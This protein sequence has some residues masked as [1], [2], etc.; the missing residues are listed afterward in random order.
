MKTFNLLH[1]LAAFG[2]LG[3]TTAA[4]AQVDTSG[5][6]C[7]SCPY[8]K[9]TS[10]SIE[11]GAGLVSRASPKF[12]DYTGL[13]RDGAHALFDGTLSRRGDD[14]YFADLLAAD[15]G[16]DSR[17]L[18]GQAGRE[19]LYSLRIGYAEIPRYLTEGASTPFLG[20]G[21]NVLT[22]PPG[23]PAGN[24]AGMPLSTTLQPIELG[25]RYKRFDIGAAVIGGQN[26]SY[27]LSVRRD[28]RDGT[29]PFSGSF[30]ST[31]SQFAAPVNETTDQLE[32]SV[33]YATHRLQ[34]TVSYQLSLYR[35]ENDGVTWSNPFFPVLPGASTGQMALAPDNH[36]Q[37]IVAT[38]G[39]D[40]T[41][42][43]RASGDFAFG[44]MTQD[45]AYLAPTLNSALAPTVPALPSQSLAGH[46]DTFNGGVKVSAAPIE[47]LR[48]TASYHRDRRDNRTPIQSYPTVTTD[49]IL[50]PTPRTN[51]PFSFTQDRFQL[52]GNYRGGPGNLK[53]SAAAEQDYRNRT[54]QEVV[55]TRETTLWGRVVGQPREDL[56]L[57]LKLAHAWRNNSTYGTSVW[58]G[59]AE[60]PLLR[61]FYLA[62]RVR[63]SAEARADIAFG[64]KVSLGVSADYA[65][66]D[67]K[68][69][70]VGLT[71]A[72]SVNLAAD[73]TVAVSE[74][75][76]VHAFAQGQ[77]INS[78]QAGSDAFAGPDWSGRVK[79]R[80]DVVGVGV[81]HAAMANKLDLG[82][83]LTIS[84]SRS[85]VAVDNSAAAPPFPTA[86]TQLDSLKLYATYKLKDNLW[87]TGSYWYE[88]YDS[89]DWQLDDIFPATIPNL[90]ALGA[91]PPRYNV[92]VFRLAL[93]YRF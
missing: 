93:R 26:W 22:L 25:Y 27:R 8:P 48:L 12:G 61:K 4:S 7:E 59:Y 57:S 23:F 49:M 6:K 9:G 73:L 3:M 34:A 15:L 18:S 69:S 76:Q 70:A 67:Y 19:G 79:D 50:E 86:T 63:D 14:G 52:G 56:S 13:Q 10:G 1:L 75:T 30:F 5:W 58:F 16:L 2:M 43:I 85:A 38:A 92:N 46:A 44:R 42:T 35:N 20:S 41:P 28:T 64:E 45:A 54:F 74:K 29:K 71:S 62:D 31:A 33:S 60:N 66:D 90:L 11:V 32:A 80:F 17:R 78:Q 87:V 24:T 84:R 40:I 47:G 21:G 89:Q 65:N 68:N 88:H 77:W 53:W 51:T 39:Y 37:Q 55:T 82:A 83:D 72:R 36:F 81:K 91:Q